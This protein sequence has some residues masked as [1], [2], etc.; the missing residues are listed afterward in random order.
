MAWWKPLAL[1]LTLSG[2]ISLTILWLLIQQKRFTIFNSLFAYAVAIFFMEVMATLVALQNRGFETLWVAHTI[3]LITAIY[4]PVILYAISRSLDLP[5]LPRYPH[6][7]SWILFGIA[8][9]ISLGTWQSLYFTIS[10]AP[11]SF[12]PTFT[13]WYWL[14]LTF[15]VATYYLLFYDLL[16]KYR[17]CRRQEEIAALRLA[18]LR[19][20]PLVSLMAMSIHALPFWGIDHPLLLSIYLPGSF[21]LLYTAIRFR[22]LPLTSQLEFILPQL[23][24]IALLLVALYPFIPDNQN[25]AFYHL[26]TVTLT[27]VAI[28]GSELTHWFH[29]RI[30]QQQHQAQQD[31]EKKLEKFTAEVTTYLEPEKFWEYVG[32]YCQSLFQFNRCAIL[33]F[34]YDVQPYQLVYLKGFNFSEFQ[35]MLSGNPSAILDVLESERQ[36]L[37]IHHYPENSVV[38]QAMN[39]LGIELVVP[40][41]EDTTLAGIIFLG[42]D[43]HLY[44]ERTHLLARLPFFASHVAVAFR[45]LKIIRQTLQAQKMAEI[46]MLASQLAH[47]FQSFIALVKLE[48]TANERLISHANYMEKLVQDLL[49]FVRPQQLNLTPI[50]INDL[51][52]MTLDVL[53]IPSDVIIEKHYAEDL[54]E[55]KVDIGEM[56]RVFINLLENSLR[57]M[58]NAPRKRIK[59]TTRRLRPLSRFQLSPWLYIEI[60]DEGEGIPEELLDKIF[61][62]F[63]TT[64]KHRGGNGLGLAIVKQIVTR[65]QGYIDVA[66]RPGKGTIFSIR[67]PFLIQ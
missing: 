58:Q 50:N 38:H 62:P 4:F 36:T 25:F 52:D 20:F 41:F 16:L 17:L 10:H 49:H 32:H 46:G 53:D 43:R 29:Q 44:S 3:R 56:R 67:I 55:V 24:L 34:Q 59:I 6:R 22:I 7:P 35:A 2:T 54:P 61:E 39:R 51:I 47:D 60:L 14:V 28:V 23:I 63:F 42:N 31:F 40:I 64:H 19:L 9:V 66:S 11:S 30:S 48:N 57:A 45:N 33:A 21:L 18:L 12:F 37:N 26:L 8:S 27:L 65:H 15:W 13:P 1:V 5:P